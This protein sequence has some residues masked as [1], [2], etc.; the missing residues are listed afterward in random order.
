MRSI[1]KLA[2]IVVLFGCSTAYSQINI[3]DKLKLLQKSSESIGKPVIQP[4]ISAKDS[5]KKIEQKPSNFVIGDEN[6]ILVWSNDLEPSSE[7]KRTPKDLDRNMW[8]THAGEYWEAPSSVT[9]E[10]LDKF[11][12]T[13]Y[14][15]LF[16]FLNG[17][18]L[19]AAYTNCKASHAKAL[20]RSIN[21]Y[22]DNL[23]L[24]RTKNQKEEI[25]KSIDTLHLYS[26][27]FP[28]AWCGFKF[29]KA[30]LSALDVPNYFSE[31]NRGSSYRYAYE[32]LWVG[33][34]YRAVNSLV[35]DELTDKFYQ[36]VSAELNLSADDWLQITADNL[37]GN[38]KIRSKIAVDLA[39]YVDRIIGG[40]I[41][42]TTTLNYFI[43]DKKLVRP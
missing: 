17:Q 42:Q 6:S 3:V 12:A 26:N 9:D 35:L 38:G 24:A 37:M 25:Q 28:P 8:I 16:K 33:Q 14:N 29:L 18:K 20:N 31:Q 23:K 32:E 1:I 40:Y 30:T 5:P 10:E 4:Q 36:D 43:A 22:Q 41:K 2:T 11:Q 39:P 15:Q 13:Y 21:Q 34:I 19:K 7:F 27:S